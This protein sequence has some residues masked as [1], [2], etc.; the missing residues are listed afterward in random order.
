MKFIL[1][2]LNQYISIASP[3]NIL[4]RRLILYY[5]MKITI[6]SISQLDC[7][8]KISIT[9]SFISSGETTVSCKVGASNKRWTVSGSLTL[10]FS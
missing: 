8:F 7:Y 10:I 5:V 1:S 6:L 9:V 3:K 4:V 2:S